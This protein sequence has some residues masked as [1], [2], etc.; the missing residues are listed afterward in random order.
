MSIHV[1]IAVPEKSVFVASDATMIVVPG[2][3]GQLTVLPGHARL[4]SL[5]SAGKLTYK[6][7]ST[8]KDFLITGGSIL[9]ENNR[10]SVLADGLT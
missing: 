1:E 8:E 9:V 5:L 7:S 3:D 2:I 10:V 6:S 4:V